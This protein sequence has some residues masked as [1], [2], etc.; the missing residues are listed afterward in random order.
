MRREH[1]HRRRFYSFSLEIDMSL[2]RDSFQKAEAAAYSIRVFVQGMRCHLKAIAS[3]QGCIDTM[4]GTLTRIYAN[5]DWRD[6][7]SFRG[8]IGRAASALIGPEKE[9]LLG[10]IEKK[11]TRTSEAG[12]PKA[13]RG[14]P[15]KKLV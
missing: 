2:R 6:Q 4:V 1:L 10:I 3:M 5:L 15:R 7:Q 12:N 14:R 9:I 13:R 8:M 11:R